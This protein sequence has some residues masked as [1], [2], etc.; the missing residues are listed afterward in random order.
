VADKFVVAVTPAATLVRNPSNALENQIVVNA[1]PSTVFTGQTS[2]VTAVLG[3]PFPP[4]SK[5]E[6]FHNGLPLYAIAAAGTAASLQV[7]TG[8]GAF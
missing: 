1:G 3:T 4:G 8:V 6:M 2:G 7:S 5:M